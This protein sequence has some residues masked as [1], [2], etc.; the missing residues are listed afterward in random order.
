MSIKFN[1]VDGSTWVGASSP[2]GYWNAVEVDGTTWVG[3]KHP[4]GATNIFVDTDDSGL[5]GSGHPSGAMRVVEGDVSTSGAVA[6]VDTVSAIPKLDVGVAVAS[7]GDSM[8][9]RAA[10]HTTVAARTTG[11]NRHNSELM[12]AHFRNPSFIHQTWWDNTATA[13]L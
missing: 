13:A 4:S 5:F 2:D 9:A 6:G 12:W 10:S 11:E 3:R 1:V 8:F 7:L